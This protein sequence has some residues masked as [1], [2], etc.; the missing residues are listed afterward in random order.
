RLPR[1]VRLRTRDLPSRLGALLGRLTPPTSAP[2]RSPARVRGRIP[3]TDW[4]RLDP[5]VLGCR[6]AVPRR[7]DGADRRGVGSGPA[8]RPGRAPRR[9][10]RRRPRGRARQARCRG[11]AGRHG[12]PR[13]AGEAH[14]RAEAQRRRLDQGRGSPDGRPPDRDQRPAPGRRATHLPARP[15]GLNR[16]DHM[17]RK[18]LVGAASTALLLGGTSVAAAAATS[19]ELTL[20][21]EECREVELSAKL[22]AGVYQGGTRFEVDLLAGPNGGGAPSDHLGIVE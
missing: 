22:P 9:A 12:T 17:L 16:G 5:R 20:K 15:R 14:R 2:G 7:R 6:L 11:P 13:R 1:I 21:S 18:L 8:P 3:A 10:P 4:T 19:G